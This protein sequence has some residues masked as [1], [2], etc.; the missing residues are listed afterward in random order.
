MKTIRSPRP[1]RD[2]LNHLRSIA[3]DILGNA[4][5]AD[6]VLTDVLR[7]FRRPAN[8]MNPPEQITSP[9]WV[10]AVLVACNARLGMPDNDLPDVFTREDDEDDEE[11]DTNDWDDPVV[12]ASSHGRDDASS[13]TYD[14]GYPVV[15]ILLRRERMR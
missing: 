7:E 5:D 4:L 10:D 6:A 14:G 15:R 9:E 3:E 2:C 8:D 12:S 13:G 1:S 11:E